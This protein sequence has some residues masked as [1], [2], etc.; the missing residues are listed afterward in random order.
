MSSFIDT[1]DEE[2]F[3]VGH[4]TFNFNKAAAE[5]GS[6]VLN[7]STRRDNHLDFKSN[8]ERDESVTESHVSAES[9]SKKSHQVCSNMLEDFDYFRQF[10]LNADGICSSTL[11]NELAGDNNEI[12]S[13]MSELQAKLST[14][15]HDT[16][17]AL[18]E[19]KR[20]VQI[21]HLSRPKILE[22]QGSYVG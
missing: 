12:L 2:A 18:D 21:T 9:E 3:M 7:V 22:Q 11:I 10:Q 8:D 19:L 16:M 14:F 17:K 20:I 4:D 13:K 15:Y 6:Y 5:G 1:S